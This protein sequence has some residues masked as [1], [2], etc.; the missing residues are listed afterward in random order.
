MTENRSPD[1]AIDLPGDVIF[2]S[3]DANVQAACRVILYL[4][5]NDPNSGKHKIV[6]LVPRTLPDGPVMALNSDFEDAIGDVGPCA[7]GGQ[8]VF[9]RVTLAE[10]VL[11]KVLSVIPTLQSK[12][13]YHA[14]PVRVVNGP[15]TEGPDGIVIG[16]DTT[17]ELFFND[18]SEI[19]RQ[20]GGL[21]L[22]QMAGGSKGM[23]GRLIRNMEGG[24]IGAV[25]AES[26]EDRTVVIAPLPIFE[27][28]PGLQQ[29]DRNRLEE[30]RNLR[31]GE[32]LDYNESQVGAA[33]E[34]FV[35]RNPGNGA[36]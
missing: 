18:K 30:L 13:V 8:K 34:K 7:L 22:A 20:V 11:P 28:I 1:K 35:L 16:V 4:V 24:L 23:T 9:N 33:M 12:F 26:P 19:R 3:S 25:I 5:H 32:R 36:S 6:A 31:D 15:D 21:H 29:L 14:E 17:V 27:N 2:G 10:N